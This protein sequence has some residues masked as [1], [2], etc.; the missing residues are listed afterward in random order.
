[1]SKVISL[2]DANQQLSRCIRE[3]E[4]GEEFVITRKGKAGGAAD[5]DRRQARAGAGTGA[6]RPVAPSSC[7]KT[8]RTAPF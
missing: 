7:P 8:C 3:V 1:M 6:A 4:A 5:P 2:R